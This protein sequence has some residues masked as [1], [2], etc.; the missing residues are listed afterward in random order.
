MDVVIDGRQRSD[1]GTVVLVQGH[2]TCLIPAEFSVR[3]RY[4]VS[5]SKKQGQKQ[6]S[7]PAVPQTHPGG[8]WG[9]RAYS[10]LNRSFERKK[11]QVWCSFW[12]VG[13]M[14]TTLRTNSAFPGSAGRHCLWSVP[15][16]AVLEQ[17]IC[18]AKGGEHVTEHLHCSQLN[19]P[20]FKVES[21][22]L[23]SNLNNLNMPSAAVFQETNHGY[24]APVWTTH[25][26][27]KTGV[28]HK[29]L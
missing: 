9:W 24:L 21:H 5:F 18:A 2:I 15:S 3:E 11:C 1:T 10:A 23:L 4:L 27:K 19:Q 8:T 14:G 28:H 12:K 16:Q 20:F 17:A 7:S 13:T 6:L 25:W 26:V 22:S 29:G